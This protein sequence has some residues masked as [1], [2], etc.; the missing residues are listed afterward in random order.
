MAIAAAS[1]WEI[2]SDATASNVNGGFFVTGASGTDFS[3][4]AAAQYNLTGVTTAGADAILLSA[5]AAA[6]MVG[7]A[8]HIISGTNFTAGW[9]EILSVVVGVSI[10]LDRTCTS[11]AGSTGVVN[12]GGAMSLGAANDD[13]VFENAVAGNKFY[14]KQ[15]TYTL[16]G[17]V[18]LAAAGNTTSTYNLMEGYAVTRGDRPTGSTRPVFNTAAAAFTISGNAWEVRSIQFT[19]TAATM[20]NYSGSYGRMINC[21]FT[22]TSTTAN[23]L[24]V[25]LAAESHVD[26][27]EIISYRGTGY[28]ANGQTQMFGCYVHDCNIGATLPSTTGGSHVINCIF[29]SN[30]T[31]AIQVNATSVKKNVFMNNTIFG[32]ATTKTGKGLYLS[33]ANTHSV[34]FVNNIIYGLVTGVETATAVGATMVN[35]DSFNCFASNTANATN[36]TLG[37]NSISTTPTFSSVAEVSGATATTLGSVLTQAGANFTTSGVVAGRD[38]IYISAGTGVTAGVYGIST[39]GTTTLTLDIAPG[40][41]ATAD[42]TFQITTGRDFSVTSANVKATGYPSAM[43]GG[44]T[45]SYNDIGAAQTQY[46]TGGAGG[47]S[48][49]PTFTI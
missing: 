24:A 39:V 37:G 13:A 43:P 45:T 23:R 38:F 46:G 35:Y 31:T 26:R 9:Y 20:F 5:S 19:G 28:N 10:T 33:S 12:I 25:Q 15:G 30:I 11:A 36:W 18:S 7:N 49:F 8:A 27:C 41:D 40:T 48:G 16:G 42:K 29:A 44:Y 22:N 21:K 2:R 17:T 47:G 14:I 6:D 4:Q 32:F 34:F 1:V 3:Q